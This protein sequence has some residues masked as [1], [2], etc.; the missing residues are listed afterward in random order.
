MHVTIGK[1]ENIKEAKN[2]CFI[3][4]EKMEFNLFGKTV[5]IQTSKLNQKTQRAHAWNDEVIGATS[6]FYNNIAGKIA[7]EISKLNFQHVK[8][9]KM[10]NGIDTLTSLDGSDIDEVLNWQ[11]KGHLNSID[12]W[13]DVTRKLL[14]QRKVYLKPQFNDEGKLK[15]LLIV[16]DEDIDTNE[17]I[18][19]VSPF[20]INENTSILDQTLSSIALKLQ[21]GRVKGYMKIG[22]IVD[23]DSEEFVGKA[24]NTIRQFQK[25]GEVNGMAVVDDKVEIKEFSNSYSVLNDEEIALIKAELLSS[26][27]MSESI[28]TGTPSQEEQIYFYQST[29]IPLLNQLE[30]ELTYK[31][32]SKSKRMKNENQYYERII[33]DNQLF[34]FASIKDLLSLYHENA[35]APLFTVNEFK[36][37]LGQEPVEGGDVYLTNLNSKIIKS[38]EE[39]EDDDEEEEDT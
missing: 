10:T 2:V 25:T 9:K 18:N 26:Y 24:Q 20:F 30:K 34:K 29:I 12:F 19:L 14:S 22:A 4:K 27:F 37:M 1:Q 38:F 5:K 15:D 36:V 6:G 31:L 23:T 33:I 21:Q 39:L 13:S 35:Q 8:Y 11:P 17:T 7:S 28:L 16:G 3:R 32:I